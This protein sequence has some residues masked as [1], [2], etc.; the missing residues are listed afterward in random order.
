MDPK[1]AEI[2]TS[3]YTTGLDDSLLLSP[4]ISDTQ[5]PESS[6][7]LNYHA[8]FFLGKRECNWPTQNICILCI[9]CISVYYV[10]YI[11]LHIM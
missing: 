10:Y 1:L 7:G 3:G 9:L 11:Y 4:V 5:G 2:H 8:R 6:L